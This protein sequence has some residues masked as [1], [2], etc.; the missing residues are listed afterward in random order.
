VFGIGLTEAKGGEDVVFLPFMHGTSVFHDI[1][2]ADVGYQ[3]SKEADKDRKDVEVPRPL[4]SYPKDATKFSV[5]GEVLAGTASNQDEVA[6]MGGKF[7]HFFEAE[8]VFFDNVPNICGIVSG[9]PF[10]ALLPWASVKV[11]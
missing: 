10:F 8:G 4:S 5:G 1:E 11:K 3:S 9:E 6:N 7:Q 2:N